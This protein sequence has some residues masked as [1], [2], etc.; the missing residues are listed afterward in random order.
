MPMIAT[1]ELDLGI[2]Q[3]TQEL[4]LQSKYKHTAFGGA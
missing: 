2:V 4:F 1:K 3:P